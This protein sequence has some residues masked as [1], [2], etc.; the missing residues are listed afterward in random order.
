MTDNDFETIIDM[1]V[2]A[3]KRNSDNGRYALHTLQCM[4]RIDE[5]GI[6]DRFNRL[7]GMWILFKEW[8]FLIENKPDVYEKACEQISVELQ[9]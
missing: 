5:R 1:L 7:L 2:T 9:K 4:K 6:D 3:G 8:G